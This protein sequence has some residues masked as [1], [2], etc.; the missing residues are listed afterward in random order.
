MKTIL[1]SSLLL[2]F[3][4][5]LYTGNA[6]TLIKI[7]VDANQMTNVDCNLNAGVVPQDK[8]YIHSGVCVTSQGFCDSQLLPYG[9][10]G[11]EH[12][13]GNWGMDDNQG[14]MTYAGN[15]VWE[16]TMDVEAYYSN[17]ANITSGGTPMANGAT[18][19]MIGCV[20][21]S[22]DG[23]F[24]GKDN[25]CG[26][27][28]I[29][30]LQTTPVA[31]QSADGT[32]FGPVTVTKLVGRDETDLIRNTKLYP[33]PTAASVQFDYYLKSSIEALSV[34]VYNSLG[35][36]VARVFEGPQAAG[37]HNLSWAG[38][39]ASGQ[40]LNDGIYHLVMDNGNSLVF[41]GKVVLTR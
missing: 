28:F 26:D 18:P 6:Q 4:L 9:G 14:L 25:L 7:E 5:A 30:N 29:K 27:I 39:D 19:Y 32:P 11:W 23:T 40:R 21:R 15:G 38:T 33:N 34:K 36:E 12:V 1:R 20:F 22:F 41:T 8:L 10:M 31:V 16:I 2:L 37:Q 3:V 17:A 24:E 13:S 35:Q